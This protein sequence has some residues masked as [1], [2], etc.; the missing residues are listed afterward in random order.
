[1]YDFR[2]NIEMPKKVYSLSK[3][4]P[5]HWRTLLFQKKLNDKP[6]KNL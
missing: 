4:D 3:L 6:P 5:L 2:D 1:M